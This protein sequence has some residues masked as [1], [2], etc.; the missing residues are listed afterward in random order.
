[1]RDVE[2]AFER[3]REKERRATL[4]KA[5]EA[6]RAY[7]QHVRKWEKEERCVARVPCC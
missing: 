3:Q 6:E 4:E 1:V 2:D 7:Q 5:A